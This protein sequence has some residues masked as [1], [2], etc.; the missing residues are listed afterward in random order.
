MDRKTLTRHA[1]W[2]ERR[3]WQ[4]TA[5]QLQRLE[6]RLP[7]RLRLLGLELKELLA[8]VSDEGLV[9]AIQKGFLFGEAFE[10]LLEDRYRVYLHRWFFHRGAR[11]EDLKDLFQALFLKLWQDGFRNYELHSENADNFRKWLWTVARN[12]WVSMLRRRQDGHSLADIPEPTSNGHSAE[13]LLWCKELEVQLE[14]ILAGLPAADQEIMR[15]T[16]DDQKPAMIAREMGLTCLAVSLRLFR[17]RRRIERALG[18]P[19]H[20]RSPQDT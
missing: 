7:V 3:I 20:K 10:A 16:L 8:E 12:L 13:Q 5:R 9:L 6:R 18:L 19:R 1:R 4:Q 11:E 15:R 14:T 17:T 2:L